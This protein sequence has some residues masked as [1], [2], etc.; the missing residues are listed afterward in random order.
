MSYS[1]DR[2]AARPDPK[3]P[4]SRADRE[5]MARDREEMLDDGASMSSSER[6]DLEQEVKLLRNHS[7]DVGFDGINV[8]R[9][10][11]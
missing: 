5:R 11:S 7:I 1:Y 10:A 3:K 9:I 2:T 4:L 8:V 6:Q